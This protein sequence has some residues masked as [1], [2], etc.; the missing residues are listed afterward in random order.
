VSSAPQ[1]Q[2]TDTT[3]ARIRRVATEL[4]YERGYYATTM[5]DIA[6]RVGIKAGSL[7]NHFPGKQDILLR[8]SLQTT[9][10]L[11]DGAIARLEGVE[12]VEAAL[13]A[14]IEWHVEFHA[15]NRLA[16]R[17]A[18]G[19]I[20]ALSDEN[21]KAVVEI[22]DAH[23]QLFKDLLRRGVEE[24]RWNP[25]DER[26][27]SIGVLTMCTEVDAWF[28]DDG[29]LTAEQV[30]SIYADFILRGLRGDGT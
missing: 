23:E 30:G 22:R 9:R 1:P 19:Q 27:I 12:D 18:D 13:R 14:Y 29:P 25:A 3:E 21:R 17:V 26:V 5:R 8:I 4:F 11:Y 2:T 6:A 10:E 24:G 7:Y 15:T 28:R 16:S 20:N